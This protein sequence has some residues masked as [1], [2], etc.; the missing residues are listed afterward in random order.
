VRYRDAYKKSSEELVEEYRPLVVRIARQVKSKLPPSVNLDDLI[1][2]GMIGL[3]D[4]ANKFSIQDGVSFE[5]YASFRV[6]GAIFD[7]CREADFLPRGARDKEHRMLQGIRI[8]EQRLGRYPKAREV[9]EELQISLEEYYEQLQLFGNFMSLDHLSSAAPP[10]A[11]TSIA[12]GQDEFVNLKRTLSTRMASLPQ[13]QQ[14][15]IALHYQYDM[16]YREIA[17]AMSLSVGRISQLHSEAMAFLKAG[18]G[19]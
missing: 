8:L 12:S 11:L 3:L 4:A 14:M 2:E 9:A 7:A 5:A 17:A 13:K 6:R 1:Q 15:V 16:S 18:V 19:T 10:D